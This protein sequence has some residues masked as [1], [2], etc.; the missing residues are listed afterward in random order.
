MKM[1]FRDVDEAPVAELNE[2]LW[3]GI[4]GAESPEPAPVRCVRFAR[5]QVV[6]SRLLRPEPQ[7]RASV[8][9][10]VRS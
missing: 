8:S 4:K 1:D 7:M 5:R 10:V 2:I 6:S 9:R 3:K